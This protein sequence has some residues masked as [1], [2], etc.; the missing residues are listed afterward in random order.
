[1]TLSPEMLINVNLRPLK[2]RE[3]RRRM[4]KRL[5]SYLRRER[6]RRIAEVRERVALR[7]AWAFARS[8]L[9]GYVRLGVMQSPFG[10][11]VA[12]YGPPPPTPFGE[13]EFLDGSKIRF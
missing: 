6:R 2:L 13:Y 5:K 12:V 10:D 8:I 11:K 4:R 1:M 9:P 3:Q 7:A